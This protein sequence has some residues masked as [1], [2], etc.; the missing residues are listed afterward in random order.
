MCKFPNVPIVFI[1]GEISTYFQVIQIGH[2]LFCCI[3]NSLLFSNGATAEDLKRLKQSGISHIV[4]LAT[5]IKCL[6]P[7][8]FSYHRIDADDTES[9]DIKQHFDG[10]FN[11]MRNAIDNGGK[12][13]IFYYPFE[14]A[15]LSKIMYEKRNWKAMKKDVNGK[16]KRMKLVWFLL[17]VRQKKHIECIV[18][19][20][21][22]RA[23]LRVELRGEYKK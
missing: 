17:R 5:G 2:K 11:F 9:Q 18:G 22:N 7:K 23:S 4:N 20:T 19:V 13:N 10:T 14:P 21:K 1:W 15:F 16:W 3:F 12:V 8:H 6:F